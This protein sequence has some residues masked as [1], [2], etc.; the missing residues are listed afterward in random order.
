MVVDHNQQEQHHLADFGTAGL[1]DELAAQIDPG[2]FLD[3]TQ[4]EQYLA[5]LGTDEASTPQG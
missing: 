2:F 4:Q 1:L 5:D 3:S